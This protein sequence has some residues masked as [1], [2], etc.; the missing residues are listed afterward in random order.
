MWPRGEP[1]QVPTGQTEFST[2]RVGWRFPLRFHLIW[3]EMRHFWHSHV[4][5]CKFIFTTQKEC[6]LG[7]YYASEA[8]INKRCK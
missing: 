8:L 1:G 4:T 3:G 2:S 6:V 7:S 5:G